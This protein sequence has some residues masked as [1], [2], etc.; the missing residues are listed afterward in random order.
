M[1]SNRELFSQKAPFKFL[2][3]FWIHLC[4]T[5]HPR[6]SIRKGVLRNF[7]KFTGKR[8]CHSL[9]F[10]KVAG[11]R[12]EGCEFAKFLRTLFYRTNLGDCVCLCSV[13]HKKKKTKQDTTYPALSNIFFA[14]QS[15]AKLILLYSNT[16]FFFKK[17]HFYVSTSLL[18]SFV[19]MLFLKRA[20]KS[21]VWIIK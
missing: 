18:Y 1:I 7:A 17:N 2:T 19:S 4:R 10:N 15:H 14:Y 12:P 6:C 13:T 16:I 8:L 21:L 3:R 11:L 5:S 20:V 9:Y